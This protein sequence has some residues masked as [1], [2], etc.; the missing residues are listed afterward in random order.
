MPGKKGGFDLWQEFW[1]LLM[2]YVPQSTHKPNFEPSTEFN[3]IKGL[4]YQFF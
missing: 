2:E 4:F 3:K 1:N